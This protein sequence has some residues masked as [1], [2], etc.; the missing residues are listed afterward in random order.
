MNYVATS[1][2]S[3]TASPEWRMKKKLHKLFSFKM[4]TVTIFRLHK[5]RLYIG[6]LNKR[7]KNQSKAK[8][9]LKCAATLSLPNL[10]NSWMQFHMTHTQKQSL[11]SS[12][13]LS[14]IISFFCSSLSLSLSPFHSYLSFPH[15]YTS[16][17]FVRLFVYTPSPNT[18]IYLFQ[19]FYYY[20]F[21]DNLLFYNDR[22]DA[23]REMVC[24]FGIV[25]KSR[26]SSVVF[27]VHVYV[28][29]KLW[30]HNFCVI[31]NVLYSRMEISRRLWLRMMRA[32][33]LNLYEFLLRCLTYTKCPTHL[34]HIIWLCVCFVLC[35]VPIADPINTKLHVFPLKMYVSISSI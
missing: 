14:H 11:L 20:I 19:W 8:T 9:I 23:H 25:I 32:Q 6:T 21:R 17:I 22:P 10:W 34:T 16:K 7:T 13:A 24:Y 26:S 4:Q 15:S 30:V 29:C 2:G 33:A 35:C 18:Q 12:L 31:M 1:Y 27:A 3:A 5:I 28:C